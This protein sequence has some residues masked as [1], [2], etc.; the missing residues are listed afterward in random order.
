[1]SQP[2]FSS[3]PAGMDSFAR[4]AGA[5][6]EPYRGRFDRAFDAVLPTLG[7]D[8]RVRQAIAYSLRSGG[9]RLR[10]AIVWMVAE[11]LH[12]T[13]S[14]DL[15][16]VAVE[17]FHSSSLIIDDLPCMDN[18][19]LRRGAPTTHKAFSEAIAIMA[20]FALTA[21]G[22]DLISRAPLGIKNE[23]HV[24]RAIY[25]TAST[26]IGLQ[27][28]IG[29]QQL[30]LEP[31]GFDEAQIM[32][33]IDLKTGALFD[34]CFVFGWLWGGGAV[35]QLDDLHQLAQH[36]GRAFQVL[37]DID[38][39]EQDR[40]AGKR[41]NYALA[42]GEEAAKARI[43]EH[44]DQFCSLAKRLGLEKSALVTLTSAMRLAVPA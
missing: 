18:D 12:P 31:Q 30:D 36:F 42:F 41:S 14:I 26:A 5:L 22:F 10:P 34:V 32:R 4:V 3:R 17:F 28:L 33:L 38:D 44:V 8:V 40:V 16:A 7:D 15:A 35:E 9:K 11:A 43:R 13:P 19:D 39:L 23:E 2:T 25:Q 20:S 24:L 21:A 6:L 37:D 27:G 29:G 1:M